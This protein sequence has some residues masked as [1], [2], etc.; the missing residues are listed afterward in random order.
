M[1]IKPLRKLPEQSGSDA[2]FFSGLGLGRA[3]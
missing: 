2:I 1:E 3:D